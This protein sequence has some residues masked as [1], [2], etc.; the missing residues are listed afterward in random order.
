M[1]L[2]LEPIK[3]VAPVLVSCFVEG[4]VLCVRNG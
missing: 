3:F 2:G 4:E 1:F